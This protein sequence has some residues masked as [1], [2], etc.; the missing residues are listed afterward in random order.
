MKHNI[1]PIA[2]AGFKYIFSALGAFILFA[3]I[4]FHFLA[5]VSFALLV[6]LLYLYRNPEREFDIYEQYSFL[7]PVDGTI[8]SVE[9]I[10]KD[11]AYGYKIKIKSGYKDLS[12]LRV[13]FDATISSAVRQYGTRLS[14]KSALSSK[15]NETLELTL[16]DTASR[17]TKI[18][19]QTDRNFDGI[20]LDAVEN[21]PLRQTTRYGFLL[22]GTVTI[23]TPKNFRINVHAG[24]SLYASTSILG[25]F[26]PLP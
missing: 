10:Q 1:L 11:E 25:Y 7:S 22:N 13:P 4:D 23:Y 3:L 2:S 26:I 9:E 8:L 12:L 19:H 17:K 21:K 18:I 14:H 16:S 15:L 24:A 5:L 20:H 6:G